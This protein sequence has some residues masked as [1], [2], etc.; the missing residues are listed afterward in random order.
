MLPGPVPGDGNDPGGSGGPYR[1]PGSNR[2]SCP[3]V[4]GNIIYV[5][6][7]LLVVLL[8]DLALLLTLLVAGPLLSGLTPFTLLLYLL[9]IM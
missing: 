9:R 6:L 7:F 1:P 2:C 4:A 3:A 5:R 8:V